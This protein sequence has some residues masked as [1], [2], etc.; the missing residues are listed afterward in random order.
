MV[1]LETICIQGAPWAL[2]SRMITSSSKPLWRDI[3]RH[4]NRISLSHS[5]NVIWDVGICEPWLHKGFT[6]SVFYFGPEEAS[7]WNDPAWVEAVE[8]Q[9]ALINELEYRL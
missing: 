2:P 7:V 4:Y 6:P 5:E 1:L 3:N 9:D 8:Y